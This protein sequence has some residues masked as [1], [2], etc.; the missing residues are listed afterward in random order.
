M[1]SNITQ[2]P[3][4]TYSSIPAK[5]PTFNG[6]MYNTLPPERHYQDGFRDIVMPQY[7]TETERLGGLI[8]SGDTV[9]YQVI[10]LT[11]E[12]IAERQQQALDSDDAAT[13]LATDIANGQ[14][15]YQR[16]FA[17]VQR[18][19]DK[20]NITANQARN[21]AMLL[22]NPLLPINYGQFIVAQLNLNA[23]VPPVN[24]KELAILNLA[25]QQI[26]EY[27]AS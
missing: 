25:K 8:I 19:Y 15:M 6:E 21:S 4:R 18:Q 23:L 12:E 5:W 24:A 3:L 11:A 22:W 9:T 16:F 20:G 13:K 2:T 7:N 26:S 14:L 27:L 17:Y 1:K 10:A